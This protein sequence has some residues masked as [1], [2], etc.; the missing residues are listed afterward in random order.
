MGAGL[1]LDSVCL[2]KRF[3]FRGINAVLTDRGSLW[4]LLLSGGNR[5]KCIGILNIIC[6]QLLWEMLGDVDWRWERLRASIM[7][8]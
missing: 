8:K 3:H 2:G 4:V 1:S 7:E 5:N 6:S